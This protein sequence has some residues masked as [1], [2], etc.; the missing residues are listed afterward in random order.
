MAGQPLSWPPLER[1][2]FAKIK[3]AEK[4]NGDSTRGKVRELSSGHLSALGK[5]E[6]EDFP[7]LRFSPHL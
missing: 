6:E 1:V 4:I 5:G 2:G 7:V 3:V